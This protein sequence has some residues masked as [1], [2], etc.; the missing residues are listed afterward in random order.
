MRVLERL[1]FS[2]REHRICRKGDVGD[3]AQHVALYVRSIHSL[4]AVQGAGLTTVI[5]PFIRTRPADDKLRII[6]DFYDTKTASKCPSGWYDL[7]PGY[8]DLLMSALRQIDGV[9]TIDLQ[10]EVSESDFL[11]QV[12]LREDAMRRLASVVSK[13]FKQ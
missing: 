1:A 11:D 13:A 10:Q 4:C 9:S 6:C 12:H 8:V 5:Q 2:D 3:L 7:S